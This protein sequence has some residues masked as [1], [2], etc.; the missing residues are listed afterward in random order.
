MSLAIAIVPE[1]FKE[2]ERLLQGVKLGYPKAAANAIN[3]GLV[4]GRKVATQGVRLRYNI[5]SRDVKAKGMKVKKASWTRIDGSLEARGTMLPV[6]LFSPRVRF[7]KG[8]QSVSVMIVRGFRKFLKGAFRTPSGRVMERRQPSKYPIYP[9]STIGV[10]YM[11]RY[12]G[13]SKNIQETI[14]RV[15]S[16]RL[17]HN[18]A[19]FLSGSQAARIS[20]PLI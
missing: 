8:R 16:Q 14:A 15:T 3:R 9:V 7:R 11:V 17:A 12:Q 4:S 20:S 1:G 6:A 2:A 5:K 10:P 18:V 19:Y 13:I